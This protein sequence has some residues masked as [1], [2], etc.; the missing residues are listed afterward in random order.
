MERQ[1]G[2]SGLI[3]DARTVVLINR[4]NN[5]G[6]ALLPL[7]QTVISAIRAGHDT[8]NEVERSLNSLAQSY[9]FM[10]LMFKFCGTEG[11]RRGGK[12]IDLQVRG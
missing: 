3:E 7:S 4:Q 8:V 12:I 5:A 10:V 2:G 6:G 11:V 9:S 1:V